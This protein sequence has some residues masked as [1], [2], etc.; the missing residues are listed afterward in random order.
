MTATKPKPTKQ[1]L[2]AEFA[3]APDYALFKQPTIA[4]IRDC[5]EA[6]IERDRWEGCGVP[7]VRVEGTS[8]IRYRKSDTLEW[9]KIHKS[10]TSTTQ[11]DSQEADLAQMASAGGV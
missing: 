10:R 2:L 8:Q 4:A 11:A 6:T 1:R 9:L 5:S 3:A 7:F